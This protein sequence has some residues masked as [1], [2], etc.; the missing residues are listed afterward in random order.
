MPTDQTRHRPTPDTHTLAYSLWTTDVMPDVVVREIQG[1]KSSIGG[2]SPSSLQIRGEK[3][4]L[5]LSLKSTT[6]TTALLMPDSTNLPPER[7]TTCWGDVRMLM[8]A[9]QHRA[10]VNHHESGSWCQPS[11]IWKL[12]LVALGKIDSLCDP[13]PTAL[14]LL[15]SPKQVVCV[16]LCVFVVRG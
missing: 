14:L 1:V 2:H 11:W 4:Q 13:L 10:D 3:I 9:C 15:T 6:D 12:W 8:L 7:L 5:S 16:C